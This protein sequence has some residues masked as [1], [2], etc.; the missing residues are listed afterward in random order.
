MDVGD[1][2]LNTDSKHNITRILLISDFAYPVRAGTERLVFGIAEWFTNKYGIQTDILTPNWNNEESVVKSKGVTIYRFKTHSIYNSRPKM[3]IRDYIKA[4]LRLEKYDVYH[5]FYTMP[6]VMSAIALAKL[7]GSKNVTSLFTRDQ[8]EANITNPFYKHFLL[9]FLK[10][11]DAITTTFWSVGKY[12]RQ[13]YFPNS[14]LTTIPGWIDYYFFKKL[15]VKKKD[16]YIILFVGRMVKEKGIYVLLDAFAHIHNKIN[17]KLI[18]IGPPYEKDV[19]ERTIRRLG[20]EEDVDLVGYVHE[21]EL[22]AWY[23]FADIVVAPSIGKDVF[24]WTL[25]EAMACGKAI[26]STEVLEAPINTGEL[27]VVVKSGDVNSLETGILKL[28]LDK[29]FCDKC[30]DNSKVMAKRLFNKKVVMDKYRDL[31]RNVLSNKPLI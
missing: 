18:L 12:L 15:P 6:P 25:M 11:S 9:N 19:V 24:T 10:T 14:N 31:Y 13:N 30:G 7:K 17:S 4:G 21:K 20:I 8:L 23:Q 5:G 28:L 29:D 1:V 3:R 16:K 27:G 2:G 22:I 26:I